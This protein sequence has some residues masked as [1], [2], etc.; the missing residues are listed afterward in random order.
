MLGVHDMGNKCAKPTDDQ[1]KLALLESTEYGGFIGDRE[2]IVSAWTRFFADVRSTS[3]ANTSE[4]HRRF[5]SAPFP[6]NKGSQPQPLQPPFGRL[7]CFDRTFHLVRSRGGYLHRL[8]LLRGRSHLPVPTFWP[9]PNGLG[10]SGRLELVMSPAG[11]RNKLCRQAGQLV[12]P[13]LGLPAAR[14]TVH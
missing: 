1:R 5:P 9:R 7:P 2:A 4:P 14:I 11:R 13:G 8:V 3:W 6:S 12:I 10:G